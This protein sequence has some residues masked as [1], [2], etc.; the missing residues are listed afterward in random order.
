MKNIYK[1][2]IF[3]IMI[4][5]TIFAVIGV[6]FDTANHGNFTLINWSYTKMVMGAMLIGIGFSVP[7]LVYDS[8]KLPQAIKVLIHMG[9]GCVVMLTVAFSV[10][11]IPLEAGWKVCTLAVGGYLVSAFVIWLACTCYFKREA[12]QINERIMKKQKGQ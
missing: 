1:F 12:K 6:F 5:C 3:G 11:W 9:I 4:S 10:G 2:I 8:E 7:A